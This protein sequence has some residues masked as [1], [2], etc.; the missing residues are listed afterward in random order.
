[1]VTIVRNPSTLAPSVGV[2][3]LI[4]PILTAIR[5]TAES[6]LP[7]ALLHAHNGLIASR[8]RS[9]NR[10]CAIVPDM[11]MPYAVRRRP[12]Q[13]RIP[14]PAP[15]RVLLDDLHP[16]QEE[17]AF[18]SLS[19]HWRLRHPPPFPTVARFQFFMSPPVDLRV[20]RLNHTSHLLTSIVG[21]GMAGQ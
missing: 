8:G 14:S 4:G 20:L 19:P 18:G 3:M 5:M 1:M 16:R 15:I 17:P 2:R 13:P 11:G 12:R 6:R 9:R 7:P 10:L 21:P